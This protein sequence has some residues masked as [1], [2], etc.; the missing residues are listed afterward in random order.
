[1][2]LEFRNLGLGFQHLYLG[3]QNLDSEVHGLHTL[4]Y[5][6]LAIATL[7]FPDPSHSQASL[8][9][10]LERAI[11][12][13][14]SSE[15]GDLESITYKYCQIQSNTVKYCQIRIFLWFQ[16]TQG[17]I[18]HLKSTLNTLVSIRPS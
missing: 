18:S 14:C 4:L 13:A 11:A 7:F 17:F 2:G 15:R 12:N 8:Q 16:T 3:F 9:S 1:M 10:K 5:K 6:S